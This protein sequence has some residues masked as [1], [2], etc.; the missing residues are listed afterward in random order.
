[1]ISFEN[2]KTVLRGKYHEVAKYDM[3]NE[4]IAVAADGKGGLTSY[5]VAN[6]PGDMLCSV[7][8]L[9]LAAQGKRLSPY[10]L[11][12]VEM[13]GRMQKITLKT[14]EGDVSITTF[15]TKDTSGVFFLIDGRELSLD[16]CFNCR[17]AKSA[18]QQKTSV[19]EGENFVLYSSVAGD[20]VREN[21]CFYLSAKGKIQL[22]FSFGAPSEALASAF[23][24]F[25]DALASCE[26]E[27]SG[28]AIPSS[29]Q[30]EEEKALYL[31]SY[32]TAL[33][34]HKTV[35][36]FSAFVAGINY[37]DPVRTYYRDSY[38]TVLPLLRSHPEL[39]KSELL[40]LA[41][42]ITE[43]GACPSA[44]KSDFTAFWGD[45]YDSPS[46][47]VME[48]Y[49]Y[50]AASGDRAILDAVVNGAGIGDKIKR[51]MARLQSL[52][53]ETGL[54]YKEGVYNKRDWADEVNRSGYVTFVEALYYRAL[55][56]AS[57]LFAGVDDAL[58]LS[59]RS[60]AE[61]V[62][63]AIND[64]LFDEGKGYYVNYK[65]KYFTE[66]N[67]SVDTVFAVLF[68]VADESR[69]RRVLCAMERLL[70]SQNNKEQEGGAFGVMC[71]Y[72]P[73]SVPRAACH[74]SSRLF[75]YHNGANWCY[76]T[77][78]YA[79]A[80]SLFEMD[81]RT[82]LLS[83]FRYMTERGYYTP[84]EYFSPCCPAGSALQA[85]SA[86]MAFAFEKAGEEFFK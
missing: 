76:L 80:K 39:V 1:M 19:V 37:L 4:S 47:F 58:A 78:M 61:V 48:V 55:V 17:D 35:G 13:V 57:R 71:V 31:A 49:D 64:L 67:L 81:W 32:F 26:A 14:E 27:A 41:G 24:G 68:G 29:V 20:W 59:Y 34:N 60:Q 5:R 83:T 75:D 73:Y 53:D 11:K 66:D 9:D 77:A 7:L 3:S 70:E 8:S 12:T 42:G 40:T 51:V 30:T 74:K 21:D 15:L 56:A 10:L 33:E 22:L 85:W 84:I 54:I 43:E 52:T 79:Y 62:K 63:K 86:A 82:P 2:G 69:G 38:F 36:D 18:S 46:F 50:V 44:V 16:L 45:H 23:A 28:V 65:N 25:E 6:H 72:P